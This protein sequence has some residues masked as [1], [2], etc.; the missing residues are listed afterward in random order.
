MT[1]RTKYTE[2]ALDVIDHKITASKYVYL[3]CKRFLE[4]FERDDIEFRTDKVDKVVTFISRLKHYMGAS[5]DKPFVLAN[6]QF[7]IIENLFG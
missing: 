6:W 5:T 2:Y 3:S 4:W 1:E 7:F